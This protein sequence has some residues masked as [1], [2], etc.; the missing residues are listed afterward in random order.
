MLDRMRHKMEID[1]VER[2]Y[3]GERLELHETRTEYVEWLIFWLFSLGIFKDSRKKFEFRSFY[4]PLMILIVGLVLEGILIKW[5]KD[6]FGCTHYRLQK[7]VEL[8]VRYEQILMSKEKSGVKW[9]SKEAPKY[10]PERYQN[11]YYDNDFKVL[12]G[13]FTEKDLDYREKQRKE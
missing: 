5:L 10:R 8:E 12:L 6:R 9:D 7:F 13:M 2:A 4:E 3:T 1:S 11:Y